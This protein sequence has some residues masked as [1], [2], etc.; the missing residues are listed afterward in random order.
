[1][2]QTSR[3]DYEQNHSQVWH[4]ANPISLPNT[5]WQCQPAQPKR[6][7]VGN[8]TSPKAK[9]GA[10]NHLDHLQTGHP[11]LPHA[12]PAL[13]PLLEQGGHDRIYGVAVQHRPRPPQFVCLQIVRF[14]NCKSKLR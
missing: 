5:G 6:Q 12:P 14:L 2:L 11:E 7:I 10:M 8:I 13:I 4:P 3:R 9:I 1:M